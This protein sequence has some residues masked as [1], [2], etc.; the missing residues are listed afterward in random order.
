MYSETRDLSTNCGNISRCNTVVN[1]HK[2]ALT[3][4]VVGIWTFP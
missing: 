3:V 4:D 1:E 2:L